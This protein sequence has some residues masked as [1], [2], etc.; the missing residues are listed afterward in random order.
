[1]TALEIM[2]K[3]IVFIFKTFVINIWYS[4]LFFSNAVLLKIQKVAVADHSGRTG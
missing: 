2:D 1:M 3:G 4:P